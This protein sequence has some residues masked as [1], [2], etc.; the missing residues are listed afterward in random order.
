MEINSC[1]STISPLKPEMREIL[2][3]RRDPISKH[4]L[5]DLQRIFEED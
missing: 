3:K 2:T 5:F 1:L 4:F